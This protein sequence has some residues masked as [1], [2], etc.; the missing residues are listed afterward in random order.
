MIAFAAFVSA[1][2]SDTQAASLL[3]QVEVR[4]RSLKGFSCELTAKRVYPSAK[5]SAPPYVGSNKLHVEFR[6]PNLFIIDSEEQGQRYRSLSNGKQLYSIGKDAYAVS[7]IDPKARDFH[8][9][10]DDLLHLLVTSSFTE[11]IEAPQPPKLRMLPAVIW[12]GKP[13]RVIEAKVEG[14]YPIVYRLYV[15]ADGLVHRIVHTEANYGR[16]LTIDSSAPVISPMPPKEARAF[17]FVPT[18]TMKRR[19]DT[20]P[21]RS[22]EFPPI[23]PGAVAT[24]FALPTPKGPRLSLAEAMKGRRAVLLNFWF[25]HCPPCRAEH[26]HLQKLYDELAPKGLGVIAIDD[27]D[28][29]SQSAAYLKGAKLSFPVVLTGPRFKVD[30]TTGQ[31][32]YQGPSLPDYASLAPYGVRECPTNILIDT[33]TG[34]V[35]YR[36][37]EWDETELRKALNKLGVR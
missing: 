2:H 30:P 29:A 17:V 16:P 25:V 3:R 18:A 4:S 15:G 33:A 20:M 19:N 8:W 37:T 5:A 27:Q 14:G 23:Q 10:H 12:K 34:K 35:V 24:D 31:T 28:T 1:L 36:A 6:R 11:A 26:P 7:D 21:L 32:D 9:Y 13:Y 22:G